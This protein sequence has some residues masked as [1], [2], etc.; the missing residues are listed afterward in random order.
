M[1]LPGVEPGSIAWKAII[2]T[3]G[4]QTLA[5]FVVCLIIIY[6]SIS[7]IYVHYS[8]FIRMFIPPFDMS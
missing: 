6:F 7:I 5:C 4:L 2:L 8:L 1:R 3:V